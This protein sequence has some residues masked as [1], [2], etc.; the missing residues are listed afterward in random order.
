MSYRDD[1]NQTKIFK[2]YRENRRTP[3]IRELSHMGIS[4]TY[5]QR[6]YGSYPNYLV[7]LGFDPEIEIRPYNSR[8][9]VLDTFTDKIITYDYYINI[10]KKYFPGLTRKTFDRYID[11]KIYRN[12]WY[13]FHMLNYRVYL[14]ADRDFHEYR[15]VMYYLFQKKCFSKKMQCAKNGKFRKC[16]ETYERMKRGEIALSDLVDLKK[17]EEVLQYATVQ[18]NT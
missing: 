9:V 17:Y 15:E 4:L 12:R 16:V 1:I 7:M 8:V 14:L 2:F 3:F 11:M 5:I 18:N 6:K 10:V 13:F